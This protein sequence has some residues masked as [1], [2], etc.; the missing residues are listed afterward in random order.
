MG[1]SKQGRLERAG[2]TRTNRGP[3]KFNSQQPQEI[4]QLY[5]QKKKNK[6]KILKKKKKKK[7]C[8]LTGVMNHAFNLALRWQRQEISEF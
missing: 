5:Q 2:P 6:K 4:K 1:Q 7:S 3:K 8:A